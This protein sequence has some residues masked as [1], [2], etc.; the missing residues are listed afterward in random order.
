MGIFFR[1]GAAVLL[2]GLLTTPVA[3]V[4]TDFTWLPADPIMGETV[5]Y[6]A[7]TDGQ[8]PFPATYK[9]EYKFTS[10]SCQGTWIDSMQTS[11]TAS[12]VE[13]RPGTWDIRLTVTYNPPPFPVH[14]PTVITKS[15]TIAPATRFTIIGGL[16]TA[17]SRFDSITVKYR[18]DAAARQ[19]GPY[20]CVNVAQEKIVNKWFLSPPLFPQFPPD[21]DWVPDTPVPEF[22][23]Q[24]GSNEIWDVKV[25]GSTVNLVWSQIPI[26]STYYLMTQNMRL[27]YTDPCGDTKYIDL[28]SV[29]LKR[30]KQDANNW[31]VT[32]GP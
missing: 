28:G 3:A 25:N 32:F 1:G 18:V 12:F 2:V 4:V 7:V 26:G 5:A 6:T 23:F 13:H 10:G 17:T 15:V 27:K 30:V 21:S 11:Q 16:N 22:Q 9:W 20:V 31:I 29:M 8:A 14:A 24:L 19:C